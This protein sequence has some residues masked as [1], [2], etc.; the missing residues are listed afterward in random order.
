MEQFEIIERIH[1]LEREI[2]LLPPG[3]IAAK[4]VKGKEYYYHRITQNQKRTETYVD[5]DQV[6]ELRVQIEKRKELETELKK[7]KRLAPSSEPAKEGR[8]THQFSTYVRIG[9]Q[10]KNLA[11]PVKKY[12]RRECYSVLHDFVFGE[13]QDKVFILYGLRRTGKTTLIRQAILDMTPEQLN[14]AAF[15]QIKAKDT[16]SGINTDLKYLEDQGYKYVFIDEVTLMEDFI[17]GAALFSD[18]YASSGMKIV[19]SGTDSLGFIFTEHEQLYDRCI[20]LHT[21]IIPYREFETVLGIEGIDEYIRYGGTMSM[22]GVNYNEKSSFA[23]SKSTGDYIDSA[24]ARNIQHSLKYYQEGGHFRHLYELYEKGE[25]TSAINRVVEDINHRFTQEVLTRTFVS[26]DLSVSARNLL[27]DREDPVDITQNIDEVAV[28][29][30]VKTM[31]DILDKEEQTVEVDDTHAYQIK[32]YLTLLD[33][34]MELDLLHFPDVNNREKITVIS[35][36]GLRYAQAD[37]LI[38]S[39]LLDEKF[40]ALSAM[41][42]N[43]ILER[44]LSEIKGRM[45]EDIVLLETKL[46]NPKKQV[47]KLQFA[48]GEFDMVVHDP[49]TL[50]CEIYEIKHSKEVVANQY[51]HLINAEKCAET[52]HR[53]GEITGRYVIYRGENTEIDGVQYLNVEQYLKSLV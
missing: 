28:T 46:A 52:E 45:M 44:I 33:L 47:F 43:R 40:N 5:F 3:S 7:L 6:D 16:L 36:P 35:Q 26:H 29:E 17:E 39:L 18:I 8:D 27:H 23:T 42:R 34:I 25:L 4:K 15:I 1:E 49:T 11:A 53:F 32:E 9:S 37:A 31:L 14:T 38:S 13:Q 21:T 2:A 10:L 50:T 30:L 19:L 24:I 20:L 51:R 41:Q 22:G 12:K 48:V